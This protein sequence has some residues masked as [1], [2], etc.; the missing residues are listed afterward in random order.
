M[1]S[2]RDPTLVSRMA[3]RGAR[4]GRSC[5]ISYRYGPEAQQHCAEIGANT[6]YIAGGST[7]TYAPGFARIQHESDSLK[8][9]PAAPSGRKEI[10]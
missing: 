10:P 6:L 3:E 5:P 9:S 4:P 7:A 8:H 2:P 1:P